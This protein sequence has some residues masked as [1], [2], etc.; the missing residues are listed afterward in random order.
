[1]P[2]H[3]IKETSPYLLQHAHNP[4]DWYAWSDE[5]LQK[6]KDENK[7]ILVSI[8]YSACHWCHV[9]EK[10]SFEDAETARLMNEYFINIKVDRE[11]RPDIDHI[12]MDAVQAMT[13]QGGW[14]LNVFLTPDRKPFY[15]GTYFPP[16]TY[17][18]RP[19]WKDVLYSIHVAFSEKNEDV[20]AQADNLI[21]HLQNANSFGVAKKE[22]DFFTE[23]SLQSATENLLKQADTV[24]GGFGAA[25][26]FPQ[27]FS[28][29]FLLRDYYFSKNENALQQALLS[30]DKMICGGIYDQIGGGFARYSTDAKWFA[31]HFEKMLYD[32]A[33]LLSVLSDAYKITK[34]I[35]YKRIIQETVQFLEREILDASGGFYS[36]LDADSEG[37]EG[38]FY[39]W[40]KEEIDNILGDASKILCAAYNVKA[41]DNWEDS[42]ILWLPH[43][44]NETAKQFSVSLEELE[45]I[46]QQSKE[47]LLAERNKRIRPNT[48]DKILLSWNAL[49][50][51]ALC[52]AFG[53]LDNEHYLRLAENCFSFLEKNMF[54]A[55]RNI[56]L[57]T[58]KND[59]GKIDAFLDDY[60]SLIDACIHLQ[61]ATGNVSYLQKA[62]TIAEFIIENFS[63]EAETFFYFTQKNQRDI[64][65][66]KKE[67]YD[68][69]TPSGNGVMANNL[70]YLSIVFDK[71]EWKERAIVMLQSLGNSIVRY[72]T[73]FGV[74][75]DALQKI[76]RGVNEIAIV[77]KNAKTLSHQLF[78]EFIPNK[79][80][81]QSNNENNSYPLLKD[82][83]VPADKTLIY[84]CKDYSCKQPVESVE[85]LL[86]QITLA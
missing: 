76:V 78:R 70:L 72:P 25:P 33:L 64:V 47:K 36:A 22:D 85:D 43:D 50:I 86:L 17:A 4:V 13:G 5:A 7:P 83:K 80:L 63:D 61:E 48:D 74:W 6:A 18:N 62:K 16:K 11:E 77:G 14:P 57:H 23:K 44:L 71:P 21:A 59:E 3:L 37:V 73:S 68:G 8:G 27:T 81:M 67:I 12:Y 1:M 35:V 10:E 9:M 40:K 58:W 49:L 46:L 38:K 75:C 56:W 41:S 42:N 54:D 28:I 34:N 55:Q 29:R 2:N 79:I 45:N 24:W 19:S 84:L 69:A 82:K 65:V 32:N 66:R 53:A 20:F 31:P 15:G 60:A 51:T 52:K 39:T 26:K 30:L